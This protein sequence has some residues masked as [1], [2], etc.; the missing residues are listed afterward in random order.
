MIKLSNVS[1]WLLPLAIAVGIALG[2]WLPQAGEPMGN[3]VDP[4]ILGLLLCDPPI[5]GLLLRISLLGLLLAI[6]LST[7]PPIL[8]LL[9]RISLSTDRDIGS[10]PRTGDCVTGAD[11]DDSLLLLKLCRSR[12]SPV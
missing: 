7:D 8:G 11:R 3:L 6:S 12:C 1:T 10:V 5:L 9:F 4:L 2:T